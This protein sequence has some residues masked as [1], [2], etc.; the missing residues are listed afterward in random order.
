MML[1]DAH[2]QSFYDRDSIRKLSK[3]FEAVSCELSE[4][5]PVHRTND[6]CSHQFL[7][8]IIA[9]KQATVASD[10]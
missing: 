6:D 1:W 3:I 2:A 8:T 5:R 4:L 10:P 9:N 7:E